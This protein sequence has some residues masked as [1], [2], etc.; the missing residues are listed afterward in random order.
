MKR[1]KM[2]NPGSKKN[3]SKTTESADYGIY[4]QEYTGKIYI[5][6]CTTGVPNICSEHR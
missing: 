4:I 2:T 1:Q 3:N 5:Y 6:I